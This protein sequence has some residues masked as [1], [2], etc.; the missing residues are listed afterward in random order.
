[1]N[2]DCEFFKDGKCSACQVLAKNRGFDTGGPVK[3]SEKH[4]EGCLKSSWPKQENDFMIYAI[5]AHFIKQA[6]ATGD[7]KLFQEWI[8]NN[9]KVRLEKQHGKENIESLDIQEKRQKELGE[10][11]L[12][13]ITK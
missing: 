5:N 12:V 2:I 3:V 11:V 1:M 4:C 8:S 9:T 10:G 6:R 7:K 13:S